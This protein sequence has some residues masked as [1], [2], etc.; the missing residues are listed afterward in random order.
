MKGTVIVP[1]VCAL[2]MLSCGNAPSKEDEKRVRLS[3]SQLSDSPPYFPAELNYPGA[4]VIDNSASTDEKEINRFY[5]FRTTDSLPV[6]RKFYDERIANLF[7]D[8]ECSSSVSDQVIVNSYRKIKE[9]EKAS[10][11]LHCILVKEKEGTLGT[12]IYWQRQG[13]KTEL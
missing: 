1:I 12:L 7:P 10:V 3:Q 9:D 13:T 6:V 8:V 4:S 5:V 11:G 2:L